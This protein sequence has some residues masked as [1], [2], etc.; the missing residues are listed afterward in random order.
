MYTK[1]ELINIILSLQDRQDWLKTKLKELQAIIGESH[2]D[3]IYFRE[4]YSI[5]T[6]LIASFKMQY[7]D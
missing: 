4:Q 5:T 2:T 3:M 6:K 1:K 7:R